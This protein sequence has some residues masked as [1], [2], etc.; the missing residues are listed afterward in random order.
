MPF[1]TRCPYCRRGVLAPDRAMGGSA[2]CPTC[3]SWFTAVPEE[4]GPDDL[5]Q[6]GS[7]SSGPVPVPPSRPIE[8]SPIESESASTGTA[9]AEPPAPVRAPRPAP[10]PELQVAKSP[11]VPKPEEESADRGA[12][13]A[14]V[15]GAGVCFLVAAALVVASF[16]STAVYARP[17]A[18]LG[19]V[20]G[21]LSALVIGFEKPA[22]LALPLGGAVVSGLVLLVAWFA[23]ALLGPGY[24]ASRTRSNYD[25]ETIQAVPLQIA[26]GPGEAADPASFV[27]ARRFALQQRAVRV[28]ITG[29]TVAPVQVVDA[30]KRFTKQQFLAVAVRVQH[31]GHGE[32]FRFTH[33][34][35]TGERPV[36][37]AV[38]T[39]DG[40][41]LVAANLG[42]DVPLGVV[43]GQ[44]VFP[45]R[46]VDDV[47]LFEAPE[48][49]PITA[50][51]VELPAEAWAGRG[52]FRFQIPGPMVVIQPVEKKPR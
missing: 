12:A 14:V 24:E 33:W 49:L 48:Q 45:G 5:Q 46:D 19:V 2:K 10:V 51:R 41:K 38:V 15:V 25:P 36:P 4:R 11:A 1:F 34:D 42:R 43:Y 28:Q 20:A 23:P 37:P 32:K 40:R 9:L 30:K 29:A 8:P 18:G 22:R 21:L 17:L 3:Q 6:P 47:L 27:D 35:T 7:R 26:S 39:A 50:I 44:D 16:Q 52:A 31:L 13:V